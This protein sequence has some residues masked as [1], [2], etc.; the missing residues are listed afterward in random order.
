MKITT[1]ADA[2]SMARYA[3]G[4]NMTTLQSLLA[5]R[6]PEFRNYILRIDGQ[7]KTGKST[8]AV[9][10][11]MQCPPPGQWDPAKP[12]ELTD[13]LY[14]QF[15]P[16]AL[17]YPASRGIHIVNALDWSDPNIPLDTLVS[18]WKSLPSAAQQYKAAGITTIVV[19]TLSTLNKYLHQKIIDEPVYGSDMERIRAYGRV[20]AMHELFFDMLRATKLNIVA[21]VHLKAFQPF[22]EEGGSSAVAQSMKAAAGKQIDKIEA[23]SVQGLR[24]PMVADLRDK[25]AG[26]WARLSD[27]VLVARP[28]QETVK[29]GVTRMKYE[30]LT[31]AEG[32]F[33]AASRWV[34]PTIN[35]GYL[36]PIIE[37]RYKT[38]KE[39]L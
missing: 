34:I 4:I 21:L 25:A 20:N 6:K 16:N 32:D 26:M 19:D 30:F 29:A 5:P 1:G 9:T 24:T 17:M 22:G 13:L 15:E 31:A 28:R 39:S 33:N 36:K 38:N 2:H 35:D 14:I 3:R 10:A 11:S 27:A 37:T 7:P 12:V 8:L 18:A 23:A